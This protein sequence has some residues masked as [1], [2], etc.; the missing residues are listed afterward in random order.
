MQHRGSLQTGISACESYVLS[1]AWRHAS[2]AWRHAIVGPGG[3]LVGPEV[4]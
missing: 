1:G 3:M 2:G 4:C